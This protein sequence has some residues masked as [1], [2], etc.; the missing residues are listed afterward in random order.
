MRLMRIVL[1]AGYRG[2]VGIEY[3][4]TELPESDGILATRDL[5]LRCREALT[6]EYS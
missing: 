5:L 6:P 3:E 2:H 1:D 4:G